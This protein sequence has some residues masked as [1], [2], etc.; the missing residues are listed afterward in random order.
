M[1]VSAHL[2]IYR[3]TKTHGAIDGWVNI[4]KLNLNVILPPNVPHTDTA[5]VWYISPTATDLIQPPLLCSLF[6]RTHTRFFSSRDMPTNVNCRHRCLPA[7]GL[8]GS[9]GEHERRDRRGTAAYRPL[10]A[11]P[12]DLHALRAKVHWCAHFPRRQQLPPA[13][14]APCCKSRIFT[15]GFVPSLVAPSQ[16]D[17][18]CLLFRGGMALPTCV[19]MNKTLR[20]SCRLFGIYFI[21]IFFLFRWPYDNFDC[22]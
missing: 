7:A 13:S 6:F 15:L 16:L 17:K 8:A 12:V 21:T 18:L 3:K 9:D 5:A 14:R 1:P 11:W 22:R 19:V 2:E 4:P 20:F 10:R